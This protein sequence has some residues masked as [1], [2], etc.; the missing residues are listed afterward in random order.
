MEEL[1]VWFIRFSARFSSPSSLSF[2]SS[3]HSNPPPPFPP[4]QHAG[5]GASHSFVR[6][7]RLRLR[8]VPSALRVLR[9]GSHREVRLQRAAEHPERDP[10]I[11]QE[12]VHHRESNQS[13]RPGVVYRAGECDQPLSEQQQVRLPGDSG[14]NNTPFV[15][16]SVR[17][18]KHMVPL[19]GNS[20]SPQLILI[21]QLSGFHHSGCATLE[22]DFFKSVL[23]GFKIYRFHLRFN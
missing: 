17:N 13:N 15:V 8:V 23:N 3:A 11:H 1:I 16:Q 9:G 2:L 10:G 20:S 18:P 19:S 21:K 7:A 4:H 12:P 14:M 6:A 5:F 22:T